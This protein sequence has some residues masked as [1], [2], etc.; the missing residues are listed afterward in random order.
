MAGR[1]GES[2]KTSVTVRPGQ[3]A[4]LARMARQLA[5]VEDKRVTI[6]DVIDRLLALW[7]S[8]PGS[9]NGTAP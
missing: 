6:L 4:E 9:A 3:R 7:R 5:A 2:G 1:T 8:G